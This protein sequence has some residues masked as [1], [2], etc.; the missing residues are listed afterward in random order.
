MRR[1]RRRA[2]WMRGTRYSRDIE[3]GCGAWWTFGS[4]GGCF[5][6][7]IRPTSFKTRMS[8]SHADST[9]TCVSPALRPWKFFPAYCSRHRSAIIEWSLFLVTERQNEAASSHRLLLHRREHFLRAP[10]DFTGTADVDRQQHRHGTASYF[11]HSCLVCESTYQIVQC[12]SWAA[13]SRCI[14]KGRTAPNRMRI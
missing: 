12:V 5:C 11:T 7:S 3:H 6:A 13:R 10:G 1:G 14:R 4:I 2:I 8:T 9:N